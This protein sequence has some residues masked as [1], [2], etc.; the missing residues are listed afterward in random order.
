M[1]PLKVRG[2]NG[3][4]ER[5]ERSVVSSISRGIVRRNSSVARALAGEPQGSQVQGLNV[6]VDG[7]YRVVGADVILDARQQ[8]RLLGARGAPFVAPVDGSPNL[9][10]PTR[11]IVYRTA[12]GTPERGRGPIAELLPNLSAR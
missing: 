11:S 2:K 3:S 5:T 1:P 6:G 12:A 9:T 4:S 8:Q 10:I 7:P